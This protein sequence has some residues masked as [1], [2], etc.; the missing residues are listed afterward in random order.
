MIEVRRAMV[1][2][3]EGQASNEGRVMKDLPRREGESVDHN[4]VTPTGR[5]STGVTE[6]EDARTLLAQMNADGQACQRDRGFTVVELMA[7]L[8]VIAILVM[9][10]VASAALPRARAERVACYSNQ[11]VIE[12]A[13]PLF[14]TETNREPVALTELLPFIKGRS[15]AFC[16]SDPSV[17]LE[18]DPSTMMVTC[19]NHPR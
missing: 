3:R 14:E 19:P 7:V 17:A 18:F 13:V 12:D 6:S 4:M 8:M 9:I 1:A 11:R 15:I 16:T 2:R 5:M 10:A